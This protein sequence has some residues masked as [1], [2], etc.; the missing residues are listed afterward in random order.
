MSLEIIKTIVDD[1]VTLHITK[2]VQPADLADNIFEDSYL[3]SSS[4]KTATGAVFEIAF[5]E[6]DEDNSPNKI[7]MRYT[8]DHNRY[9]L[10]VEQK[11]ANTRFKIQWDRAVCVQEKLGRLE[12]L[13]TVELPKSQVATILATM[14]SDFLKLSPKLQLVA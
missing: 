10:L 8:Y 5:Q 9:L 4:Y 3:E 7:T 13:L 6:V 11:V 2:G 14:P 1:L 12:S